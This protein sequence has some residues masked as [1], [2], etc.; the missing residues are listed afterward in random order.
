[1]YDPPWKIPES[2]PLANELLRDSLNKNIAPATIS[3][4][5]RLM[6]RQSRNTLQ[7]LMY[8]ILIQTKESQERDVAVRE[9][10]AF[11]DYMN[12]SPESGRLDRTW[13]AITR[14]PMALA[15]LSKQVVSLRQASTRR[16]NMWFQTRI[17]VMDTCTAAAMLDDRAQWKIFYGGR[18]H[19]QNLL[20]IF[21]DHREV[22]DE[23]TDMARKYIPLAKSIVFRGMY[24]TFLGEIHPETSM[25]F[26]LAFLKFCNTRCHG[27]RT[28]TIF[29]E[30]HPSNQKD[31]LQQHITCNMKD[32]HALQSI[33]CTF[34]FANCPMVKNIDVDFRH[35]E[36]GFLR[37][38]FLES[39]EAC[40]R[41]AE[42]GAAWQHECLEYLLCMCVLAYEAVS[43][44]SI[45]QK[46]AHRVT[47][48]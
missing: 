26:S 23:L 40:E 33:R 24:M 13:R 38:D 12:T 34:P 7:N 45:G 9:I 16:G 41:L 47:L 27:T 36:L 2:T 35:V 15:Y 48:L 39:T 30:K 19:A 32:T 4:L 43:G 14:H 5:I 8:Q 10:L 18:L 25:E 21:D 6:S 1:M 37:Y 46:H 3:E 20:S 31:A 29:I 28:M 22:E 17:A 44:A 11:L 42:L